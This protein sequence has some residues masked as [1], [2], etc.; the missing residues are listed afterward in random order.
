MNAEKLVVIIKLMMSSLN[1]KRESIRRRIPISEIDGVKNI[2]CVLMV[3]LYSL[4]FFVNGD[5]KNDE[6]CEGIRLYTMCEI[7]SKTSITQKPENLSDEQ[8]LNF[9]RTLFDNLSVLKM[10]KYGH[11]T[12]PDI[13]DKAI[14]KAIDDLFSS[15]DI[16]NIKVVCMDKCCVCME[17]TL[18]KTCCGH[19]LCNRC[20]SHI[21]P[22]ENKEET[23]VKCPLCRENIYFV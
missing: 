16:S 23:F 15:L 4:H 17:K 9:S 6:D 7:N 3:H 2:D 22:D 1:A 5:F 13:T 11:F 21:E 12:I 10:D 20:W 8:I 14:E 19:S 18:T